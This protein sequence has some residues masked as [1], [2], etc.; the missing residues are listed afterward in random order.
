MQPNKSKI[1]LV[2][3]AL[4]LGVSGASNAA[5][6]TYDITVTTLPDVSITESKTVDFFSNIFTTAGKSCTI[7]VSSATA[8]QPGDTLMQLDISGTTPA[9]AGT[10]FQKLAGDGCIAGTVAQ[11]GVYKITGATGANVSITL[12]DATTSADWSFTPDQNVS[13]SY[14]AATPTQDDDSLV[15]VTP[16][17]PTS[18]RLAA[19][20]DAG[21]DGTAV[22]K[23][24]MLVLGGTLSINNALSPSTTYN[25]TFSI[26]VVYN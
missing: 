19:A 5:T 10:D 4:Y 3:G 17:T 22:D 20:G 18:L 14:G 13:V 24:L 16:N 21:G 12:G 23:E 9:T 2:I 1:A 26:T 15:Y 7:Q 11:A 8:F 6:G 25:D